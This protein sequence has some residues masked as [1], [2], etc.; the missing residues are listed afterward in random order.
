M[1][2]SPSPSAAAA[3]R[4]LLS[5]RETQPAI[6]SSGCARSTLPHSR[7]KPPAPTISALRRVISDPHLA[8]AGSTKPAPRALAPPL[9]GQSSWKRTCPPQTPR[10]RCRSCS[11]RKEKE[12]GMVKRLSVSG[13]G[14]LGA[15]SLAGNALATEADVVGGGSATSAGHR[16][17]NNTI[18]L[19]GNFGYAYS[20]GTGFGLSGRFQ[21]TV[22]PEGFIE[23][24]KITDDL[25]IEAAVDYF[26]YSWDYFGYSWSY[27]EFG[28]SA[29][30]VWN[31]W[32]T[33]EFA[34]YPRLGLGFAFGS[35]SD[36]V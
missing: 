29:S 9:A 3:S 5:R 13:L 25:G 28:L 7:E 22:V 17:M 18:S 26:H 10:A 21:H 14:L 2:S 34:A 11:R 1:K 23:H 24:S 4:T 36:N 30:A 35:W 33:K 6:S 31:V 8:R 16:G 32:F 19:L 20:A 27:N 15:L 12:H